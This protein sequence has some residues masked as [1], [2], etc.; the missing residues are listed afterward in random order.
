[1]SLYA[2]DEL[3][4]LRT[5]QDAFMD[6]ACQIGTLA[7]TQDAI[8]DLVDT[9][10]ASYATEQACG[11]EMLVGAPS[12]RS[13]YRTIDGTVAYAEA[14]LRIAHD[15]AV[16]ITSLVKITKRHGTAITPIVYEVVGQPAVGASG[17]V[18]LLRQVTT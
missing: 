11:L 15:A 9:D 2:T 5:C 6:D 16:P 17:T 12:S 7:P 14:R 4:A 10:G 13:E 18:C 3:E 1:M 8:G